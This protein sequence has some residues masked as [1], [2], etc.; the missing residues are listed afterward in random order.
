MSRILLKEP[1]EKCPIKGVQK[2]IKLQNFERELSILIKKLEKPKHAGALPSQSKKEP[3]IDNDVKLM[4]LS[5]QVPLNVMYLAVGTKVY[6]YNLVTKEL[7]FEFS[8]FDRFKENILATQHKDNLKRTHMM[9]YDYDDKIIVADYKQLRMWDFQDNKEEVPELTTVMQSPLNVDVIKVNRYC[10]EQG[11]RINIFYYVVACDNEFRVY[12]DKLDPFIEG[13]LPKLHGKILSVEF[14]LDTKKLYFGTEKGFI[15]MFDLP[16][17]EEVR[18]TFDENG[19]IIEEP[20]PEYQVQKGQIPKAHIH[21]FEDQIQSVFEKES[22][23][24]RREQEMENMQNPFRPE[25]KKDKDYSITILYRVTGILEDD[26]F[27][28]H[29][30][31][32]GLKVWNADKQKLAKVEIPEYDETSNNAK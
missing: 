5:S 1:Q 12:I 31:N 19:D 29:V 2:L 25:E 28:M 3:K 20:L 17:P 6:K 13:T 27:A 7:L 32:S 14:G 16:S 30:K 22:D 18:G 21:E 8:T 15:Y 9:L 23:R 26:W 24:E 10:E 4:Q 11:E